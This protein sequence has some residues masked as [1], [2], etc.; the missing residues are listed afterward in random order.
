MV[1]GIGSSSNTATFIQI[2]ETFYKEITGTLPGEDCC[3]EDDAKG[4]VEKD[5][6]SALQE[7]FNA[8][9]ANGDGSL[10][11]AELEEG[12]QNTPEGAVPPPPGGRPPPGL[13]GGPLSSSNI[14]QLLEQQETSNI[15]SEEEE[16]EEE[17]SPLE[18][19]LESLSE[20]DETSII[21]GADFL[22]NLLFE[23]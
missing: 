15:S 20:T 23:T 22:A 14:L 1:S 7:I 13:E 8:L 21:S 4:V 2:R 11:Q 9:D 10:T 6:S 18:D 12:H 19:L 16:E 5:G 17:V 3:E